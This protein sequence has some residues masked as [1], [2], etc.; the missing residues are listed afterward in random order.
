MG[1]AAGTRSLGLRASRAKGAAAKGA[2]ITRVWCLERVPS[3]WTQE[4]V[5]AIVSNTVSDIYF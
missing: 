4:N 2:A 5:A 1:I 3:E